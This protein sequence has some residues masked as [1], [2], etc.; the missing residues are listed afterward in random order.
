MI[1]KKS[2]SLEAL[3][4]FIINYRKK[5]KNSRRNKPIYIGVDKNYGK[6]I[7]IDGI[8]IAIEHWNPQ[9]DIIF[10]SHA[11]M[12]HIPRIPDLIKKKLFENKIEKWFIC[13]KITKEIAKARTGGKFDF[14]DSMWL[15]GKNLE[16]KDSVEYKGIT[17]KLL[18]NG[19]TY[20]STSLL[21]E[22]SKRILYTSDFTVENKRFGKD[23]TPLIGLNP[24]KCDRLITECTYGSPQFVFPSFE[25]NRNEL[26]NFI[27]NNLLDGHPT[28]ILAY[29]FGKSQVI[30]NMLKNSFRIILDR[31]ISQNTAI[32]QEL[33]IK[34]NPWEPYGNYDKNILSGQKDYVLIIP[35]YAMF[36]ELYKT[37]IKN[38]AK[39]VYCSGKGI[40]KAEMEKFPVDNYLL[41][42]DH[43][44]FDQLIK[45][46]EK[47]SAKEIYLEHGLIREFCYY[48]IKKN[49]INA[50]FIV[51]KI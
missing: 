2:S 11:H 32:L 41:Y 30:L 1:L 7:K 31:K 6:F 40:I 22:G 12:D 50:N 21:I 47:S 10:I 18:K 29:S 13:S 19:H 38:S 42:S 51:N 9:A 36:K 8:I 25:K 27:E 34:F 24:I 33:G 44:G 20:G 4:K 35:P 23:L 26:N 17:L 48:L 39:V 46:T 49:K 45:F 3:N 5:Q 16:K 14:P 15:L 37:L 43:C 28:L